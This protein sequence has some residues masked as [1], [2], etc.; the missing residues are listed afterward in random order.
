MPYI[1]KEPADII[2]TAVDTTTGTF[3]GAVSAASVDADGGVTV[4]NITIDGTEI[5]LSSG[6]LTLDVAGQLV[7]N[8]DSGQVV[9][10]DDTV[11]WGNLQ[12][13][14][15]DFII[16][17]L[18]TDKDI[19]I[20]GLDGSST[21][22]ALTFDMS[23][24]GQANFNSSIFTGNTAEFVD[25]TGTSDIGIQLNPIGLTISTRNGGISGIFGRQASDGDILQFRKDGSAVGTLGAN[26]G[27]P[28][29]A[30]PSKGIKFGNGSANP[31]TN[32]GAASDNGYD[33][34]STNVRWKDIY[35]AGGLFVGGTGSANELDDYEE[36]TWTPTL[37]SSSG[38]T[39]SV[40]SQVSRYTK[41]GR[42]CYVSCQIGTI[43]ALS[44]SN[45]GTLR[46]D[47]L[48]FNYNGSVSKSIT[49]DVRF[50]FVNLPSGIIQTTMIQNSSGT[51]NEFFFSST[52]DDGSAGEL[53]ISAFGTNSD[54]TF[55]LVYEVA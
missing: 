54:I 20:Q 24:A 8:S 25:G 17:S 2:A 5:D 21:I 40:D 42:I 22:D 48:P 14:S 3:S 41:I 28:Y 26:G 9:L 10:Q 37:T 1:G 47:G 44:G 36:G 34:G 46:V 55:S 35:L 18:G 52:F 31:V 32:T 38:A 30:G 49:S 11:N 13:S 16:G 19:K 4:D 51:T 12:N 33:L 6:N 50:Q 53:G 29:I 45:T 23:N 43:G 39:R 7:I 15:G 27:R